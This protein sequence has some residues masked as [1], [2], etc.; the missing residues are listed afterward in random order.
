MPKRIQPKYGYQTEY[1]LR[2]RDQDFYTRAEIEELARTHNVKDVDG[3]EEWA[4][5]TA[6]IYM[7]HKNNFD[8]RP[9]ATNL[10]ATY[11]K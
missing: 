2:A 8:D 6:H 11:S 5:D 7:I 1:L 9:Y 10:T 4:N 3:F